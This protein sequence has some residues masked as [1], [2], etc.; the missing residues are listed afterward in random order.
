[1]VGQYTPS[2]YNERVQREWQ[3]FGEAGGEGVFHQPERTSEELATRRIGDAERIACMLLDKAKV[4]HPIL[5]LWISRLV[6]DPAFAVPLWEF[7]RW[8]P[9]QLLPLM[10]TKSWWQVQSVDDAR[11][12]LDELLQEGFAMQNIFGAVLD[13]SA[14]PKTYGAFD[15]RSTAASARLAYALWQHRVYGEP[16]M[17]MTTPI[18]S[19]MFQITSS[20]AAAIVEYHRNMV[21]AWA[22]EARGW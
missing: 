9:E 19:G 21:S 1:M 8:G 22:A 4:A 6:T 5:D 17:D 10:K 13:H 20:L 15:R 3:A 14:L 12:A 16:D 7:E 2:S 11:T 18:A